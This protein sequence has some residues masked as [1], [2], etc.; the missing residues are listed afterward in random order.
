MIIYIYST[1]PE[2]GQIIHD[3]LTSKGNLCFSFD[4]PDNIADTINKLKYYPDLLILDY[5]IY[6]HDLFNLRDF[7]NTKKIQIPVIFYNDPCLTKSSRPK[8]WKSQIELMQKL[9][10]KKEISLYDSVFTNLAELIESK[11]LS[12]YIKLM[13]NPLPIPSKLKKQNLSLENIKRKNNDNINDFKINVKLPNNLFYLLTLF[14]KNKNIQMSLNEIV[15]LYKNDNKKITEE[16]LKVLISKL[17]NEIKKDPSCK[18]IISN[19]RGLYSFL[20]ISDV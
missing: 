9:N 17:R 8:H 1:Q 19:K 12:P 2:I 3:H 15:E 6:N 13:Q 14:Q 5:T 7:F 10:T 18:F 11:E 4:N 20:K 16:S